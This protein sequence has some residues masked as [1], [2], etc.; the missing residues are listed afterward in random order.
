MWPK[1]ILLLP[2]WHR[3]AKMLDTPESILSCTWQLVL[4]E[5]EG[6][7]EMGSY[8]HRWEGNRPGPPKRGQ[9]PNTLWLWPGR[10]SWALL[11]VICMC[12]VL[13]LTLVTPDTSEPLGPSLSLSLPQGPSWTPEGWRVKRSRRSKMEP[14]IC[15]R[16]TQAASWALGDPYRA[17]P[18]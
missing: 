14:S 15:R 10:D 5:R 9:G 11:H 4:G 12:S 17:L 6:A 3:D 2:M 13:P 7:V 18:E 16:Q 8:T 1:T